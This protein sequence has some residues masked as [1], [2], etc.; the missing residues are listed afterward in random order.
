MHRIPTYAISVNSDDFQCLPNASPFPLNLPYQPQ[1]ISR[2]INTAPFF[3][4][5]MVQRISSSW[6]RHVRDWRSHSGKNGERSVIR[7]ISICHSTPKYLSSVIAPII[8][9]NAHQKCTRRLFI[10]PDNQSCINLSNAIKLRV[11]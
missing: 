1:I 10:L 5:E 2:Q 11:S 6:I 4:F 9:G 8:F 7:L 3:S